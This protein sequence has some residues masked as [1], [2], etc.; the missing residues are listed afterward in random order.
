MFNTHSRDAYALSIDASD[1]DGLR[2][3]IERVVDGC[4]VSVEVYMYSEQYGSI[5]SGSI[6]C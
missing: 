4:S 3:Y 2:R 1:I 5:E 6:S